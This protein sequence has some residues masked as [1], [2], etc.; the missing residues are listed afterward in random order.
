ML[1]SVYDNVLLADNSYDIDNNR[2]DTYFKYTFDTTD[3][4]WNKRAF[5]RNYSEHSFTLGEYTPD[6]F[7]AEANLYGYGKKLSG[8]YKLGDSNDDGKINTTDVVI[9]LRHLAGWELADVDIVAA[10]ITGDG[11]VNTTDAVV[12]LRYL[13]GW[14]LSCNIGK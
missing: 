11:K 2:G 9:I 13:A 1:V 14:E 6:V 8:E 4:A 3:T 7:D 12:I 5:F 10:D